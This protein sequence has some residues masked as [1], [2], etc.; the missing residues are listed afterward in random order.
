MPVKVTQQCQRIAAVPPA[1]KMPT[2]I[3]HKVKLAYENFSKPIKP[4][5]PVKKVSLQIYRNEDETIIDE[6]I[7]TRSEYI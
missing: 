6:N 3:A 7:T 1:L 5:Q 2:Q 4:Q